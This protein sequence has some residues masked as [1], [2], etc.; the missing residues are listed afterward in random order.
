MEIVLLKNRAKK[1]FMRLTLLV[2]AGVLM[3][4]MSLFKRFHCIVENRIIIRLT[5]YVHLHGTV[6]L[7]RRMRLCD[8]LVLLLC[9][10]QRTEVLGVH[11][12]RVRGHQVRRRPIE[13]SDELLEVKRHR[14]A[15]G[16][17]QSSDLSVALRLFVHGVAAFDGLLLGGGTPP[18]VDLA[19]GGDGSAPESLAELSPQVLQNRRPRHGG[20]RGWR[21]AWCVDCRIVSALRR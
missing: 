21:G 5:L 8:R 4:D 7:H 3:K 17:D 19:R 11:E 14:R 20:R 15:A 13:F 6:V 9:R 2:L 12:L 1:Q 18:A 16:A 10:E